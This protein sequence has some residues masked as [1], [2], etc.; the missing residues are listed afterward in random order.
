MK[1]RIIYFCIIDLNIIGHG[2]IET[3]NRFKEN[4]E[5]QKNPE[6]YKQFDPEVNIIDQ[7]TRTTRYYIFNDVQ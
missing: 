3:E 4:P 1:F 2:I 6:E 7:N 5:E